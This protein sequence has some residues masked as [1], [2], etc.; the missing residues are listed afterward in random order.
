MSCSHGGSHKQNSPGYCSRLK[1]TQDM[2]AVTAACLVI[3]RTMWDHVGGLD[4]GFAVAYNDVDLCLRLRDKGYRVIWTPF[5]RL[6]HQES[7][8]RSYEHTPEKLARLNTEKAKLNK[9]WAK[10]INQD[11]YFNPNLSLTS[12]DCQLAF[13]P[14]GSLPWGANGNQT[15]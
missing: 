5:A 9:R 7:A 2:S 1:L 8:S 14:R 4:E 6:Y 12:T 10:I 13:P 3:K 15:A 11:P